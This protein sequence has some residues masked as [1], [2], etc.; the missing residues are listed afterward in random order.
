MSS[1][2]NHKY[3]II[4]RCSGRVCVWVCHIYSVQFSLLVVRKVN[5]NS[6]SDEMEHLQIS[7]TTF[8]F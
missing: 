5:E 1:S 4:S 6:L 3:S 7:K 2:L 8:I